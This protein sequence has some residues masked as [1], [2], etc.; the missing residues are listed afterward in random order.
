MIRTK[1]P[2]QL[3][4]GS[5][6][7][8]I[9]LGISLSLSGRDAQRTR[10]SLSPQ[11]SPTQLAKPLPSRAVSRGIFWSRMGSLKASEAQLAKIVQIVKLQNEPNPGNGQCET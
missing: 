1:V 6:R 2:M 3:S 10:P 11:I 9:F 4:D 5:W 7:T 8:S